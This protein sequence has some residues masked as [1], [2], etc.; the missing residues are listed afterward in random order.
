MLSRNSNFPRRPFTAR[1]RPACRLSLLLIIVIAVIAVCGVEGRGQTSSLPNSNSNISLTEL[2]GG[3]EIAP[4]IVRAIAMRIANGDEGYNVKILHIEQLTPPA[5]LPR[6]FKFSPEYLRDLTQTTQKLW[7]KLQR[8]FRIP[9]KQIYFIG[10]SDLPLQHRDDIAKEIQ[11]KMGRAIEFLDAESEIQLGIAGNIPRRYQS[12][13]K[14]YDNRG[15]S[16]LLEIG[17]SNIRGGYQ[18]IRQ[19][20]RGGAEYDFVTWDIPKGATSL[21]VEVAKAV[22]ENADLPTFAKR[23]AISSSP[24]RGLIRAEAGKKPGLMTR[25]K[26]YLT[27]SIVWALAALLYPDELGAYVPLTMED[28]NTFHYRATT[29]PDALLNPDLS[30][31][32]DENARNEARRIREAV[33]AVYTPKALVAGAETLKAL[34]T[35][36]NLGERRVI[37]TRN[38]YIARILSYVRLQPE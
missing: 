16:L 31:I 29:D 38:S 12:N 36:L 9:A 13:G 27:G 4:G 37:Y 23:A 24:F 35:E 1:P 15:I 28:I 33:K 30:K 20:P 32:R 10:L 19:L 6:D 8:D 14:W 18:Q 34:A 2:H 17:N 21:S 7:E 22:G 3:I 11:G 5:A 25:K 26:V